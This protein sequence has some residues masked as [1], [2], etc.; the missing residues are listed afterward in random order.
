MN[1]STNN[2]LFSFY[3]LPEND[4]D[5]VLKEEVDVKTCK[6][7]PWAL[8]PRGIVVVQWLWCCCG[9]RPWS[10]RLAPLPYV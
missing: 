6:N 8:W 4:E 2:F 5:A 7:V 1:P 10:S 3:V 9:V